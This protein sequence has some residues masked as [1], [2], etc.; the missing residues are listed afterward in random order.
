MQDRYKFR[1]RLAVGLVVLLPLLSSMLLAQDAG[2]W[3]GGWT[4][5][6]D[7]VRQV[8]YLVLRDG[9]VSGFHCRDCYNPDQLAFVDDGTLDAKGLHFSLYRAVGSQPPSIEK[10]DAVLA[11]GELQVTLRRSAALLQFVMKRSP[12][13]EPAPTNRQPNQPT[14]GGPRTLPAAA[15]VVT[16]DKVLGLW[17]WGIGPGK[18]YFMF[19]RHKDG[20]RGMVCG[21]CEN[22][23]DFA[24]LENI[25][26]SGTNFHFDI[27]HEDN[28]GGYEEHGPFSNVTNAVLAMNEMHITTAPSFD[29]N[30]RKIEMS[31]LGPVHYM[32]GVRP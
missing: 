3:R 10:V 28:G 4:A 15:T 14:G 1:H 2:Q 17:L 32:P 6:V 30:G 22:P 11:Q 21:P 8:L 5:D 25:S 26:M 29:P 13:S 31:L 23:K 16:A 9:K 12:P 24:P 20:L 19:K 18:Q 27:V 7:G